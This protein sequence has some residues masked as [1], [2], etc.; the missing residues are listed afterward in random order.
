MFS[1]LYYYS[2]NGYYLIVSM[3]LYHLKRIMNVNIMGG[4]VSS[5]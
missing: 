4:G 5:I 2:S 3:L 1:F